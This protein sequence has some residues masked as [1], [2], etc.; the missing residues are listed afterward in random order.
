[1]K[2]APHLLPAQR[3]LMESFGENLR[4]AR[5]RRKLSAERVAERAGISRRTLV[6]IE[7]GEPT[8]AMGNYF[9]VMRVLGLEKD[10]GLLA[11]DDE[12]GRKLQDMEL[13]PKQRAPKR[14]S[15]G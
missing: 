8:V 14:K 3:R 13:R 9:Q 4:L 1:M 12:M 5:L 15:V 6:S 10:F 7:S 11:R 2:K